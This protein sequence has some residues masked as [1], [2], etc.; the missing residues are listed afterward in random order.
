MSVWSIEQSV[1]GSRHRAQGKR[2]SD[3][4]L[5]IGDWGNGEKSGK[6]RN[7]PHTNTSSML[8]AF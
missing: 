8:F 1:K 5:W 6:G 7:E 4:E 3:F 2:I